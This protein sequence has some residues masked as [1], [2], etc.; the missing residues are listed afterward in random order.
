MFLDSKDDKMRKLEKQINEMEKRVEQNLQR[1]NDTVK[2]LNDIILRLQREN[3]QLRSER[4]FLVER[5][6]KMLKRVLDICVEH[7]AHCQLSLERYMKC[8]FGICGNCCVD[9]LGIRLCTDGPVVKGDIAKNIAEFGSYH[10]D[11]LGKKHE[12]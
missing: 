11:D 8:G 5:H 1:M 6:K 12:F 7:G 10:R 4:D 2:S 3:V 9:S